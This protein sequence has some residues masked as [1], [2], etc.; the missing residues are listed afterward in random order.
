MFKV[1]GQWVS[2]FE[3]ESAPAS[4]EAVPEAAVIAADDNGLLKPKA[5]AV[6]KSGA[7]RAGLE[8]ALRACPQ[9]R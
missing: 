2:P 4:R 1:S 5:F 9:R 3:V 7:S 8:D 6:P